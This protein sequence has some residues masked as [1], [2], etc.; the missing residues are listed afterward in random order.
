M[1]KKIFYQYSVCFLPCLGQL[2]LWKH[3]VCYYILI[4]YKT[5]AVKVTTFSW[6]QNKRTCLSPATLLEKGIQHR[7]ISVNFEN[8]FRTLILQNTFRRLL[9]TNL[10]ENPMKRFLSKDPKS[11]EICH[12][13]FVQHVFLKSSYRS[14][15]SYMILI[16]CFIL[17]IY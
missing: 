9:L 17:H 6:A 3:F 7:Y 15:N 10:V 1:S 11:D 2:L 5:L 4:F 12:M 14:A 8:F 16:S 13:N